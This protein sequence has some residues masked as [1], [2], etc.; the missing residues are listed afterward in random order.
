L[1]DAGGD[2]ETVAAGVIEAVADL[3]P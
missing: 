1:I 3:L 2:V